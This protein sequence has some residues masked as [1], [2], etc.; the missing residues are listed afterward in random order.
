MVLNRDE[1]YIGVLI[2]DLVTKG[3]DEPYRMFTSRSEYRLYLRADNADLRL[4]K[5]GY[6]IGC[7]SNSRYN[8]FK[9]KEECLNCIRDKVKS[10]Y[11]KSS[12][13]QKYGL[14]FVKSNNRKSL[15]EIISYDGVSRE[16]ISEILPEIRDV[17]QEVYE[18][19]YIESKY[20]G[21]MKRQFSDIELFKKD[22]NIKIKQDIDYSKIGGLSR[23]VVVKLE[24]YKPE[25][26][27]EASRISGITPAAI[28][29]ILGYMKSN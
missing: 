18:Q 27:G 16:T 21:Y 11:L 8:V 4:T 17:S 29:A 7:V 26:I 9:I 22:E 20:D 12:D 1:A 2:D 28:I 24:K 3:V 14:E 25:T 19:L 10:V 6:D 13:Y 23:E 15:F 5:K